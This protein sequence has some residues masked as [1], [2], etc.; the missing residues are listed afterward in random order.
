MAIRLGEEISAHSV[1]GSSSIGNL[2]GRLQFE[3][4]EDEDEDEF[5]LI[6][7]C[8]ALFL[9]LTAAGLIGTGSLRAYYLK[10]SSAGMPFW[11]LGGVL[12]IPFLY[13]LWKTYR[14][15]RGRT[16]LIKEQ[17]AGRGLALS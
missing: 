16:V 11:A 14:A 12:L 1:P 15:L 10:D 6:P 2:Q 9:L 8:S 13:Y 17:K 7:C 5:P 4:L 3:E